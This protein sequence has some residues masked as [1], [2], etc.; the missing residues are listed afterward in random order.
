MKVATIA[1]DASSPSSSPPSTSSTHLCLMA[2][3][4]RKVE[5]EDESSESHSH[6]R[7]S[8]LL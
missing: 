7:N 1:I 5:S 3:G 4:D 2:K 8:G 6:Y